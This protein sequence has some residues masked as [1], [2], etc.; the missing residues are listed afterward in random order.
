MAAINHHNP[1]STT[2][3]S[4]HGT[5]ISLFQHP[6]F[7]GEGIYRNIVIAVGSGDSHSKSV[8]HLP[9]FYTD[10]PH[11]TSSVKNQPVPATS[12]TSLSR[13][14]LKQHAEVEYRW[15]DHTRQ[16]LDK[17]ASE[18]ETFENT[19]WAAYHASQQPPEDHAICPSALLPLF[20]ESA[21]TVAMIKHS[22]DV[23]WNAVE[24]LNPGQTP[25]I[26]FDQPLYALAKQI[27]WKWPEKYGEDKFVIMF[28]G[29]HIEM[30]ALKTIGDWLQGSGWVQALVHV[31]ITTPG[32]ADSFLQHTFLL[33]EELTK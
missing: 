19:S 12:V 9:H 18:T 7:D 6:H 21:H 16:V 4:F 20:L 5:G 10:V 29:L 33:Q 23:I 1:S 31:D 25:V 28:G 26:A 22:M 24:H 8:D 27:Q 3:E 14:G 17:S 32:T 13:E 30:A 15:L 2:S 11:V